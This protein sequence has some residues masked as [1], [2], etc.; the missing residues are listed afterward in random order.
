VLEP[1]STTFFLLLM[2]LFG[3]TVLWAGL[4]KQPVFRLLAASL[5]FIPA[6]LFGVAAVNKYY[7]YYE[8]WGA[9]IADFTNRGVQNIPQ[10][11]AA[12]AGSA[13]AFDQLLGSEIN[14]PQAAK[15]GAEI[16]L[17]VKGRASRMVR[18]VIV[19]LPPQYFQKNYASY[20]FPVVE[21]MHGQPGEPEDW[22]AALNVQAT[23]QNLVRAHQ[24]DPV[25]LVMPDVNGGRRQS[26]QCLNQVGGEA[27]ETFVAADVPDYV[28][29]RI[30][31]QPP[32]QAWGIAGYSEGGYCAANLALRHPHRYGFAGV[33][34]GYFQPSAD[35]IVVRR[36]LMHVDPF[37]GNAKLRQLNSPQD[38]VRSL[39]LGA[40]IPQFWVSAA[41]ASPAD[42]L[43]ATSFVNELRLRAPATPLVL[44]S[45]GR[46]NGVA[47]RAMIPP[48]LT[49]MTTRLALT[50][51]LGCPACA[52]P[53]KATSQPV[54]PQGSLSH[55][56]AGHPG[57]GPGRALQPADAT[58]L[59]GP[60]AARLPGRAVPATE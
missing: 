53:G 54:S 21:L 48:M 14:L 50:V 38:I 47:W 39:P 35:R 20:R 23:L 58:L 10:V 3:A 27:D 45:N 34:S 17:T 29:A 26:L 57:P 52:P 25:V 8:T 36:I 42:V 9:V 28:A 13:Q 12:G 56:G 37:K 44:T 22:I 1:Q 4:A 55:L 30:R 60:G 51:A 46:H 5:A 59:V 43:S 15:V 6:M 18:A 49:W 11:P 2:A 16:G 33:M 24:A 19:Y 32:G 7:G 41:V 40:Q 31:V